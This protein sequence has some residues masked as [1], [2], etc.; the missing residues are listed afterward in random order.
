MFGISLVQCT[1]CVGSV[2]RTGQLKLK[3][4]R[5]Y[6]RYIRNGFPYLLQ[7]YPLIGKNV[8]VF[9]WVVWT[10]YHP[11]LVQVGVLCHPLYQSRM[12]EMHRIERT[13]IDSDVQLFH[14]SI[15][16]I[17][18][19][20]SSSSSPKISVNSPVPREKPLLPCPVASPQK[21]GCH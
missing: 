7:P 14:Y 16:Q 6:V 20:P 1:E 11:Y 2:T 10:D 15:W 5:L 8:L 12:P 9:Q 21:Q 19:S 3:I 4:R 13:A 17:S 18:G